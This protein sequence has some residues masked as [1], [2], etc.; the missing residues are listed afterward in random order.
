MFELKHCDRGRFRIELQIPGPHNIMNAAAAA[1]CCAEI[2]VPVAEIQ[3]GLREFRGIRRRCELVR[4][5]DGVAWIDDY[6]HHPTAVYATLQTLRWVFGKRRIVCVFQPHQVLRLRTLM[7]EFVLSFD[8]ADVV[9]VAP[10]FAA[11]ET[12]SDEPVAAANELAE[13]LRIHGI[14]AESA[15]SLDQIA[16]TLEYSLRPGDVIV[17][18]GAGDI[19][20]IQ[21]EFNRRVLGNPASG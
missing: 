1:V 2:G 11:R 16:T 14:H 13:K 19:D 5:A 10:V 7:S 21:Y 12:S 17:T 8:Q 3:Q 4:E 9:I 20:R 6:A 18:M 15:T